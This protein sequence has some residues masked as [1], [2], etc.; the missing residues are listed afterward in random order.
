[1][2]QMSRLWLLSGVYVYFP[3]FFQSKHFASTLIPNHIAAFQVELR[4]RGGS[5]ES[6]LNEWESTRGASEE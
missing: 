6:A 4:W 1:M 3:T 2:P 5:S